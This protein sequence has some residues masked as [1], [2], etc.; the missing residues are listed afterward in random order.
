MNKE[1]T[2]RKIREQT[3][4]LILSPVGIYFLGFDIEEEIRKFAKD[5]IKYGEMFDQIDPADLPYQAYLDIP[6]T[7]Y[8]YDVNNDKIQE[9]GPIKS[10][11]RDLLG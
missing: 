7:N 9:L 3:E 5:Y 8:R 4:Q 6:N 11:V 10:A 1:Q 2:D